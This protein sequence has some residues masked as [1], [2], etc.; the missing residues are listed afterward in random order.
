MEHN[1]VQL[2]SLNPWEKQGILWYGDEGIAVQ[3]GLEA[4]ELEQRSGIDQRRLERL[5]PR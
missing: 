4:A 1:Q 2:L 5:R 3:Q